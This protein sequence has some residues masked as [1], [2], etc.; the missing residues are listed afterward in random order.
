LSKDVDNQ[1]WIWILL[2]QN[3]EEKVVYSETLANALAASNLAVHSVKLIVRVIIGVLNATGSSTASFF[4]RGDLVID[5]LVDG[6]NQ[7]PSTVVV[8][9]ERRVRG[10]LQEQSCVLEHSWVVVD[11]TSRI[12]NIVKGVEGSR[13]ELYFARHYR[14]NVPAHVRVCKR[15]GENMMRILTNCSC[16]SAIA[17]RRFECIPSC[18]LVLRYLDEPVD[19]IAT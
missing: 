6:P 17:E 14:I 9:A 15:R 19:D 4:Q 2:A 10:N 3:T 11:S 8:E 16:S 1:D 13:N 7:H 5:L 18:S 12:W